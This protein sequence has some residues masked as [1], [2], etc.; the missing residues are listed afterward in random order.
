M[1]SLIFDHRA[2]AEDRRSWEMVSGFPITDCN[3]VIVHADRRRSA[4]RRGYR[5][6]EITS[7]DVSIKSLLQ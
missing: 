7:E 4:E 5:L 3:D 2:Q 1:A 6:E